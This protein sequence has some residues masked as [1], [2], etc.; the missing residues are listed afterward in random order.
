[1]TI[2]PSRPLNHSPL[3]AGGG[4]TASVNFSGPTLASQAH[5]GQIK[6]LRLVKFGF[7][8]TAVR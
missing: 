5:L 6:G 7:R 3:P 4:L 8:G 2:D 1:M